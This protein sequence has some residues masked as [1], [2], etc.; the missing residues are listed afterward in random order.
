MLLSNNNCAPELTY[1]KQKAI[2]V[3][4]SAAKSAIASIW[5]DSNASVLTLVPH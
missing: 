4:L 2:M 1:V 3:L 5:K